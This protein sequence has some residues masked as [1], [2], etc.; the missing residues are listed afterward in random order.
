VK[1]HHVKSAPAKVSGAEPVKSTGVLDKRPSLRPLD[2]PSATSKSLALTW[3]QRWVNFWFLPTAPVGLH[4]LRVLSGL[5]FLAWLLPFGGYVEDFFGLRGWLDV[6]GYRELVRL[7]QGS[8]VPLGWSMLYVFGYDASS[9][10]TLYWL[11]LVVLAA[12]TLGLFPR[13]TSVLTWIIVVSFV[14]NPVTSYDAE[15]LLVILAFYLMVGYLL[16]GL[17]HRQQSLLEVLLGPWDAFV[18][19]SWLRHG[20]D[21]TGDGAERRSY[22]ANLALRLLQVHFAIVVVASALHKLQFGEWWAG[23]A[24]WFP[25]HPPYQTTFAD[26]QTTRFWANT[27]LFFFSLIHY[28]VLAWQIGLPLFAWRRGLWRIVLV[29]GGLLGWLGAVANYHLPLFGPICLLGCLSFVTADEWQAVGN[30]LS[31][32][33]HRWV[34]DNRSLAHAVAESAKAKV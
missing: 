17:W 18:L 24:L 2:P 15:Y 30:R 20:R 28:G 21:Q 3:G 12:F 4:V 34:R 10:Q 19:S 13:V 29:G 25:M 31:Q 14:A 8:P 27:Y 32:L 6:Q 5:L 33:W 26:M 9:L 1:E 11:S 22:A 23:V 16:Y 7:P